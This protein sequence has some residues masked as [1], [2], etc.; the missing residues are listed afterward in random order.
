MLRVNL[1]EPSLLEALNV[2]KKTQVTFPWPEHFTTKSNEIAIYCPDEGTNK[3]L[4]IAKIKSLL[5]IKGGVIPTGSSYDDAEA[6]AR[7]EGFNSFWDADKWFSKKY[8]DDW[9]EN[10]WGIIQFRDGCFQ[11]A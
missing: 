9:Q 11:E 4:G 2:G 1:L 10:T 3:I 5:K 8:G 7:A 6:W